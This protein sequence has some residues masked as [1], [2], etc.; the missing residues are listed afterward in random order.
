MAPDSVRLSVGLQL[1]LCKF[2]RFQKDPFI[3]D[4][5]TYFFRLYSEAT[6]EF[7][8]KNYELKKHKA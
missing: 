6:Y 3:Y 7:F 5:V 4:M 8:G 2:D 1:E